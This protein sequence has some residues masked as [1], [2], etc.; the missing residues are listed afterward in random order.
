MNITCLPSVVYTNDLFYCNLSILSYRLTY[1]VQVD[2]EDGDIRYYSM[3]DNFIL[4]N[5][6][7][8]SMNNYTIRA[9]NMNNTY[10][11]DTSKIR[12]NLID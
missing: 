12:G 9:V 11:S 5:K 10:F 3:R 8:S 6:A 7:Y 4:I 2:F 1:L